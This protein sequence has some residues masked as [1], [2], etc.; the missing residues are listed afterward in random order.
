M[1]AHANPFSKQISFQ[2]LTFKCRVKID[3]I[4]TRKG[5]NF[6]SCGGEK[7]KKGVVRKEGNVSDKTA[8]TMVVMFD[9]P[10]TKLVKCS[11]DSL[12]AADEDVGLAYA[13]YVGLLR[14]LT[15]IIG[16][17]QTMEIKTHTYYEHGTFESFT[18]WRI[19]VEEVVEE[20][21]GSSN[22]NTSVE[23]NKN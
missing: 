18:C 1:C 4:R 20:D 14:D 19:A 7:C 11:A 13:D 23:E 15:N 9:E 17:T 6:P 21:A 22:V 12:V 5:W 3:G 2:S 8:S 16:T 10:T